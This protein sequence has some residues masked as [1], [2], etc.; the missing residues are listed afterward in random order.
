MKIKKHLIIASVVIAVLGLSAFIWWRIIKAKSVPPPT[1]VAVVVDASTSMQSDC[2]AHESVARRAT[3]LIGVGRG[4][5]FT[6]IRTG[7][8]ATRMEPQLVF[9]EA[10]PGPLN[11][12]PFGGQRRARAAREAF[13][14]RA[15]DACLG[16]K[17]TRQSPIVKAVRRGLVHLSGLGCKRESDCLLIV[18]SDLNDNDEMAPA[19]RG[20]KAPAA[21]DNTGIR[22]VLCGF[23]GTVN[24]GSAA[25]TD[26]M[27]AT[28]KAL[29]IE[30]VKFAPF[31]GE[32]I[33]A[34]VQ[35]NTQR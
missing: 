32:A 11:S 13:V 20:A 10:I 25:N 31:C 24:D 29:L 14:A 28:W 5:T 7:D 4:S 35:T 3:D 9:Q 1:H 30:P 12:G 2:A 22:V 27:L 18:Q 19:S 16:V 6:I 15:Q 17:P 33:L 26:A 8:D 21:L 23:S 34:E